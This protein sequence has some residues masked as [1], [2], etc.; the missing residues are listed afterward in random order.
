MLTELASHFHIELTRRREH[1]ALVRLGAAVGAELP[2]H[3]GIGVL[4]NEIRSVGRKAAELQQSITIS[5]EQDRADFSRV[6]P[7][8]RPVVVLRGI[9]HR[10][11]LRHQIS[12]LHRRLSPTHATIARTLMET[13]E[14]RARMPA[15]LVASVL[16]LRTEIHRL[17]EQRRERLAPFGGTALPKWLPHFGGEARQLG[18]SVWQQ[19][20]PNVLPRF[21]AL[22]GLAVGWWIADTFTSSQFKSVLHSLGIGSGGKRVV[23]G[24]TYRAMIFWLPVLAAGL[25]AYLADRAKVLIERRYLEGEP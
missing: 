6:D 25:C 13:E 22:A 24:D 8:M 10:A 21:P 12:T 5:L 15:P 18:R 14:G 9:C 17:V 7:H 3:L 1:R 19:L 11:I 20:R 23:S 4:L 2:G 16:H